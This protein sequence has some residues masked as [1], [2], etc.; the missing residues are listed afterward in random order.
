MKSFILACVAAIVIAGIGA[1]VL[2]VY[3]KPA[4]TAYATTGV[5]L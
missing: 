1:V 5:R 3:Q 2:D 4:D